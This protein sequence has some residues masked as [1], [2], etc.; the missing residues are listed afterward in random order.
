[1]EISGYD[2]II[3]SQKSFFELEE[4]I[5]NEIKLI[6]ENPIIDK[7]IEGNTTDK[8]WLFIAKDIEMY[9][10][11]TIGYG[12]NKDK[13][14]CFSI[15]A[16]KVSFEDIITV[17][18]DNDRKPTHDIRFI[19]DN[20]W[21]YTLVLPEVIEDSPFSMQIYNVLTKVLSTNISLNDNMNT[22]QKP[23]QYFV[24]RK[25]KI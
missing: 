21:S 5:I 20:V 18:I 7:S 14:G 13:E 24:G 23:V 8:I 3:Y 12:L 6:W 22:I 9:N 2:Y 19:L 1:M 15:I 17:S 11:D 16:D 10:D 4:C 25:G